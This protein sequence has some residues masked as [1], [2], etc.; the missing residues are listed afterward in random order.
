[1]KMEDKRKTKSTVCELD[2]SR[3]NQGGRNRKKRRQKK[4]QEKSKNKRKNRRR[5]R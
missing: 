4:K 2:K 5:K 1:M 3:E